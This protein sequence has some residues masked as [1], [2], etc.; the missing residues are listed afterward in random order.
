MSSVVNPEALMTP[1]SKLNSQQL[2]KLGMRFVEKYSLKLGEPGH[3]S[4]HARTH[5]RTHTHT[6]MHAHTHT[7]T[8]T[9]SCK[10]T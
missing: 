4:A 5:T 10:V 7:H 8:H 3:L 6:R 1:N 2:Y 9:M